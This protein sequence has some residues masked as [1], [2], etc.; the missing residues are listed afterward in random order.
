MEDN[1]FPWLMG[2]DYAI[3][4]SVWDAEHQRAE[5]MQPNLRPRLVLFLLCAVSECPHNNYRI[6]KGFPSK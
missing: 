4:V 2:G 3:G 5:E 1:D 6:M